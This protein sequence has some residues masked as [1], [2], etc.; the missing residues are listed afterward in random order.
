M[1]RVAMRVLVL[2]GYLVGCAETMDGEAAGRYSLELVGFAVSTWRSAVS[3]WRS[4]PTRG[5]GRSGQWSTAG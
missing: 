2:L 1:A 5:G 3:S 4:S